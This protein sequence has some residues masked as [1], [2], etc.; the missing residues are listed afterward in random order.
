VLGLLFPE[1]GG[2]GGRELPSRCRR[3][4][5]TVGRWYGWCCAVHTG[6]WRGS[7]RSIVRVSAIASTV[8]KCGKRVAKRNIVGVST[9]WSVVGIGGSRSI[10]GDVVRTIAIRWSAM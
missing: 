1:F 8:G 10:V 2:G 6:S 4:G 9:I 7:I 3:A 5:I